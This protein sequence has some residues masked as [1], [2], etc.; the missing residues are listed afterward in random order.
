MTFP[1]S[2]TTEHWPVEIADSSLHTIHNLQLVDIDGDHRDEIVVAGWE[3]VFVLDRDATGRWTKTRLGTGNQD[4]QP[5]KGSSEVKVGRLRGG[6]AL[7]RHD[8]AL[9]WLS[10][11]R[12]HAGPEP[13]GSLLGARVCW[14]RHVIAEPLQWGHAVWTANLDDDD[15]DELIIG[16]R[17]PNKPGTAGPARTGR[18]RVRPQARLEPA[19]FRAAHYRRRRHGLR[20]CSGR[21]PGRRRP[22]G[23]RRRRPGHS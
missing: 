3:G 21:R 10:G 2:P 18:L 7:C 4:A 11:R 17:D 15:D 16:Q 12:L 22:R 20:R 6:V 1:T 13:T 9:A 8:R 14:S 19:R 23:H 5:F